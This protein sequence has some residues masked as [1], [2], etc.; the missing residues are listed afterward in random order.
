[1]AV[2]RPHVLLI[3][4]D[5]WP[6]SLLG[7]AGHPRIQ[8]PTLDQLA[9]NGV[10]FP[11]AYSE[12]PV[13]IP[14]RRTL[15]TG[16]PPRIH[17]DRVFAS[18]MPMPDLPTLASTFRGAGYQAHAVGKLHV[19]PQRDRIGFDD[20]ILAEEGRLQYGV[21]D[22]YEQHLT[23]CGFAGQQFLHGMSNNEYSN[24]PWHLPEECHVTN[25]T[26]R[27]M[28]R[29]IKRRDP[30]LPGFWYLSYCHPHPPLVPLRDYLDMYRE[31]PVETPSM[32][33][34]AEDLEALPHYL[35]VRRD[36]GE[37]MTDQE[38]RSARR[39]FYAMCTHIDHQ[40]RVVIGTLREENLLDDTIILFTSDHGDM[41]GKHGLWAKRLFLE[42]SAQ[43]PMILVAT[44]AQA[45]GEVGANRIDNRLVGWQ[46]VMP[47]LLDLAGVDAPESVE[48]LSMVGEQKRATLFGEIGDGQNASRMLHDGRY[49]LIYYSVG[50][51]FQLFDLEDDPEELFDL[52]ASVAHEEHLQRLQQHLKSELYGEDESWVNASGEFVGLEDIPHAEPAGPYNRGLTG[53]RGIHYPQ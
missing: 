15:M 11:R 4:T 39:A 1:M 6:G 12:T 34:W 31:R 27:E 33:K 10:R 7:I 44:A 20:V 40:L 18:E 17:G 47:T 53:Q 28:V 22:D 42:E 38:V 50:N 43:V 29:Q 45:R 30:T 23:Q 14:A 5:H 46:D 37:L 52:S 35:R 8:T 26:T 24:R 25:W 16:C 36:V 41:L 2:S 49:K 48:G 32:G 21:V 51:R 19:Y 3:T 9:R 13:C